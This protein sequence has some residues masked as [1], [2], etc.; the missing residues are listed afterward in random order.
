MMPGHDSITAEQG[1][2]VARAPARRW[3]V[4]GS[5]KVSAARR[6]RKELETTGPFEGGSAPQPRREPA[7]TAVSR[8]E[9]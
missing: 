5:A 4:D 9:L 3:L 2:R 6:A 8:Y 1:L 7:L